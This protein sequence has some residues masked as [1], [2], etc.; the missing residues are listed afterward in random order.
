M[1]FSAQ[2]LLG[3]Q[4][5]PN[6]QSHSAAQPASSP[7]AAAP[8]QQPNTVVKASPTS[9][10]DPNTFSSSDLLGEKQTQPQTTTNAQSNDGK[11]AVAEHSI[12]HRVWSFINS[13]IADLS[14]AGHRILPEGIKTADLVKA[15]AFEKMYGEA[16]IPGFNDFDTKAEDHFGPAPAKVTTKRESNGIEHPYVAT[17]ESHAFKNAVKTFVAG[18]AKDASDMAAS[19][20]SPVGI[21]T[22]LAGVGPEAKAGSALAKVAPVAKVLTGTAFGAKGVHDI[23]TAG[24]D[25][26][27]EAWQQRLQGAAELA[28]G[29]AAV[30]EPVSDLSEGI[31]ARRTARQA[32]KSAVNPVESAVSKAVAKSNLPEGQ[33][34]SVAPTGEDI[35]PNLQQG[36]RDT[37]DRVAEENGVAKSTAPSIRD[38]VR[39]TADNIYAKSKSQF[40]TLD[41][42]TG[43]NVSRFDE[44]LRNVN[45]ALSNVTDDAEEAKLLAR[46]TNLESSQDE[47]FE[48]ARA[49]GVDPK[50]VDEAKANY[51]KAQALYDVDNHVKMSTSGT[52]PEIGKPGAQTPEVLD[53][54][55]LS[56]RL[57]KVY[58]SGR[59]QDAVGDDNAQSLLA[60]ADDAQIAG[61]Q[62]KE[63]VPSS[64][65]GQKALADLVRDN[66]KAKAGVLSKQPKAATEWGSALDDFEQMDKDEQ[67]ARFGKD[68]PK[69]REYLTAQARRQALIRLGAKALPW[70]AGAALGTGIAGHIAGAVTPH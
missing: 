14:I 65:T 12:L 17:P 61:Q 44:Q 50:L 31:S 9:P 3:D 32:A 25:N 43:G 8:A 27:P 63:F 33:S 53:P 56:S 11:D 19:F 54:K 51:K 29:A 36:I 48:Q 4:P 18:A 13:P 2:E 23:Y 21:A 1:S 47:A 45:R 37:M 41:E 22:T 58:D 42:A 59:L 7:Q 46:K 26:T 39:E 49:Q 20:T 66:T 55:K 28:G 10:Q 15:A 57:N 62:I 64:P 70:V 38:V 24:T 34:A 68:V 5:D 67:T 40:A 60:H 6:S 16:Y 52:R 35:Q 69:V 30:R